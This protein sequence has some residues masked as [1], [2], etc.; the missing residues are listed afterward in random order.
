MLKDAKPTLLKEIR[1]CEKEGYVE[2]LAEYYEG[3]LRYCKSYCPHN[4][5]NP[6]MCMEMANRPDC[7]WE[8]KRSCF[9][10]FQRLGK[11]EHAETI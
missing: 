10:A 5:L 8:L 3:F 2:K 6:A 7:V 9:Q 1:L 11:E 4:P